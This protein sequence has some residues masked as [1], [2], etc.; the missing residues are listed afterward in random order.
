MR[1][2]VEKIVG[3][4]THVLVTQNSCCV[5]NRFSFLASET[6][7]LPKGIGQS[8]R[9]HEVVNSFTALIAIRAMRRV[10]ESFFDKIVPCKNS[11]VA[12]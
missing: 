12:E 1:E 6:D 9:Y 5:P 2:R 11:F 4:R 10:D 3:K 8:A 7:F